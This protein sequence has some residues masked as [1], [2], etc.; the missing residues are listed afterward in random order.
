MR[1]INPEING[2]G[3]SIAF[4]S[5]VENIFKANDDC[6]VYFYRL[7]FCCHQAPDRL[8]FS[9][10]PSLPW[11]VGICIDT[12]QSILLVQ[13]EQHIYQLIFLRFVG[14]FKR[15]VF[16][17]KALMY[18]CTSI[19][20]EKNYFEMSFRVPRSFSYRGIEIIIEGTLNNI[21]NCAYISS[22]FNIHITHW[23]NT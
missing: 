6:N 14:T 4:T 12:L 22:V 23:F 18:E 5:A 15:R 21:C 3:I 17:L 2:T 8:H 20:M 9:I 16:F 19:K 7:S 1:S 10:Y 11:S 13:K